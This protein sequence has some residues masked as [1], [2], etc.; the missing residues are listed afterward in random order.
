MLMA[1]AMQVVLLLGA[2]AA[3]VSTSDSQARAAIGWRLIVE[4]TPG[5]KQK[6]RLENSND[7]WRKRV[8]AYGAGSWDGDVGKICLLCRL[9]YCFLGA[10]AVYMGPTFIAD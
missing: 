4:E 8:K 3:V 6:S 1:V 5:A 10:N 7:G 2:A 9:V